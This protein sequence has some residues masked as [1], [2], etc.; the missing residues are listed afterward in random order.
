MP[1][2]GLMQARA[3]ACVAV[4]RAKRRQFPFSTTTQPMPR[5]TALVPRKQTNGITAVT[6]AEK[7]AKKASALLEANHS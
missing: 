7:E 5:A 1:P 6:A 2:P 4:A 3:A